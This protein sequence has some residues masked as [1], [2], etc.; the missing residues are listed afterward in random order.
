VGGVQVG[1]AR[2]RAARRSGARIN[3]VPRFALRRRLLLLES[4][5]RGCFP[6]PD[7]PSHV[8]CNG[9]SKFGHDYQ[10][11]TRSA[12]GPSPYRPQAGMCPETFSILGI[13]SWWS[14]TWG[15]NWAG[16]Q[17]GSFPFNRDSTAFGAD[18][19]AAEIRGCCNGWQGTAHFAAGDLWGCVGLWYS[20]TWHNSAADEYASRVRSVLADHTWLRASFGP[21]T[22]QYQCDP[23]KGCPQ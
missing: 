13:M 12:V 3:L 19:Y 20:G 9:L 10:T 4:R 6:G 23:V 16:N 17:N 14:P 8:Y 7:R 1:I 5:V 22:G 2:Q 15:F 21:H 11:E 18:F